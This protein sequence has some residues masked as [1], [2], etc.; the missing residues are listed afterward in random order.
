MVLH[1]YYAQVYLLAPLTTTRNSQSA[2]DLTL[3]MFCQIQS[4]RKVHRVETFEKSKDIIKRAQTVIFRISD[5]GAAEG[6][7]HLPCLITFERKTDRQKPG[8]P[9][10]ETDVDK[11]M[12]IACRDL[13]AGL[14]RGHVYDVGEGEYGEGT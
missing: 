9:Q 1:L 14:S 5:L 10:T 6:C 2:I 11:C 3:C 8:D 13:H 4:K 12:M 7:K